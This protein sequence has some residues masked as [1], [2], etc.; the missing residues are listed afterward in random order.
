MKKKERLKIKRKIIDFSKNYIT[1]IRMLLNSYEQ[2]QPEI[3]LS[4]P[5]T[6]NSKNI[7]IKTFYSENRK[8]IM[9]LFEESKQDSI[10]FD[11]TNNNVFDI[12]DSTGYWKI[13]KGVAF[14]FNNSSGILQ[15]CC[16]TGLKPFDLYGEN[17][18]LI[19]SE[20]NYT[21]PSGEQKLIPFGFIFSLSVFEN[22][23]LD[24]NSFVENQIYSYWDYY[25]KSNTQLNS[26]DKFEKYKDDLRRLLLK[27]G[28]IFF[29]NTSDEKTIDDFMTN[30]PIILERTLDIKPDSLLPQVILVN[31]I[32]ENFTQDMKPDLICQNIHDDWIILD[33][34]RAKRILKKENTA[35]ADVIS[36]VHDLKTQ[37]KNYREYFNEDKHRKS[38]CDVMGFEIPSKPQAIGL[39]GVIK[40]EEQKIFK[41]AIEDYPNWIQVESYCRIYEKFKYYYENL[42]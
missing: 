14:T 4:I 36:E 39:I 19:I 32:K 18:K 5:E 24:L 8:H 27:M 33:Y 29:E 11:L 12:L 35:R 13:S 2:I 40:K 17:I 22:I 30:N 3:R 25:R 21:L 26:S 38:F 20:F 16:V 7:E 34:K 1:N 31:W 42:F 37:L 15:N 28:E 10:S 6:F 9:I 23:L 41:D